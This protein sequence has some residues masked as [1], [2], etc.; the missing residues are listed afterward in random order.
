MKRA[1]I[2]VV[3]AVMT[4]TSCTETIIG[5]LPDTDRPDTL[6]IDSFK[7][8]TVRFDALPARQTRELFNLDE[9]STSIADRNKYEFRT[10]E[11]IRVSAAGEGD[12]MRVT[13][14][15]AK[16]VKDVRVDI[17]LPDFD[18]YV[19]AAWIDSIPAFSQLT[20]KPSVIGRRVVVKQGDDRYLSFFIPWLD[21]NTHKPRL[22]SDDAHFKMLSRIKAR[23]TCY[24][25]NYEGSWKEMS[26]IYA[27]EW[28]VI[29][30]NYTYMMTTEEYDLVMR[31]F[32]D[33]FGGDLYGNDKTPFTAEKY[34]SERERFESG[35]TFR[36]GRTGDQV[37]GLGGGETLGVATWNFYSHYG[38]YSGWEAIAHEFMHCM[39]YSHDSNMTYDNKGVGWWQFIYQLHMWLTRKGDLPYN[40]RHLL[41]FT[42]E[43][44]AK[45][46]G[47][48]TIRDDFKTDE[49]MEATRTR[50]YNQSPLVKYLEKIYGKQ[51]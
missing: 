5:E 19:T 38:S 39:G 11:L 51:Q 13:S 9:P 24:Y 14:Y 6:A 3:S 40:D 48:V 12:S 20:F 30:T 50:F 47:D 32:K 31:N 29:M 21:A 16:P 17:Y 27:R 7:P 4:L 34:L 36:L 26:P 41:D 33:V 43:K 18:T 35:H 28:V 22:V 46:R 15:S 25:S 44:N 10:D 37:A 23:W 45:Y 42:N 2:F 49:A 1:F 8:D